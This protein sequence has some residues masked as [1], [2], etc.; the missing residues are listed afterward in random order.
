MRYDGRSFL[1]RVEEG[2]T[3]NFTE[4]TYSSEGILMSLFGS[5]DGGIS[6]DRRHVL[7]FAGR[8]VGILELTANGSKTCTFLNTDHLGTPF[9]ATDSDGVDVWSGGFEPFGRDWRE[10][11]AEDAQGNGIFLRFPGQ[12]IET[13]WAEASLGAEVAYNVHRWYSQDSASYTRPD[14]LGFLGSRATPYTYSEQNPLTFFDP[15]GLRTCFVFSLSHVASL[16][17]RSL[18]F[19]DHVGL[20]FDGSCTGKGC[21]T[22]P[23]TLYDPSGSFMPRDLGSGRLG[24]FANLPAA[25]ALEDYLKYQCTSKKASVEI[26]CIQT[27]CC[28]ETD[29][30]NRAMSF[31]GSGFAQCSLGVGAVTSGIGPFSNVEP[32]FMPADLRR[33]IHEAFLSYQRPS[34]YER[35]ACK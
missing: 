8:P 29:I 24:R 5:E 26:V 31:G 22:V 14:P 12:W 9:V 16:A 21:P 20:Y 13:V 10:G 15:Q 32:E 25:N 6:T 17:G 2:G 1:E 27:T 19:V 4:P 11:S 3:G 35:R 18:V 33:Q 34:R 28:E 23:P 30:Q 7:Y